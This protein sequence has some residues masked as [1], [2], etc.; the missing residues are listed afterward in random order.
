MKERNLEKEIE[1]ILFYKGEPLSTKELMAITGAS[2]AEV[3]SALKSLSAS[4]V[5]RGI[6]LVSNNNEFSLATSS[7]T[8]SI[9]EKVVK[10]ELNKDLS[11]A[12]LET[13]SII[14]Y[15]G[16]VTRREIEY[17]RGVNSSFSLRALLIRGLIEKETSRL[18]ERIFLYKPSSD[19][20]LH[21]GI[22]SIE[23]LPE[24][25]D[26]QKEMK[27][28]EEQKPIESTEESITE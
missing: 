14:A 21:L 22:A 3:A 15:K 2:D 7:D 20:L 13:L 25:K 6:V 27:K 24:W 26:I 17:I 1:A 10:D 23:E 28:V 11:P 12:S 18:D 5:D 19:L 16:P 9:I 4:L 8:A